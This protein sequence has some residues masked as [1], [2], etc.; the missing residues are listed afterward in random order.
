AR[1]TL[2]RTRLLSL[3]VHPWRCSFPRMWQTTG[4]LAHS[5]PTR[6]TSILIPIFCRN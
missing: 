1:V 2:L 3:R 6:L 5:R 4:T